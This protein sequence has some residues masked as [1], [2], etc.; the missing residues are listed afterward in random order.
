ML[1][2]ALD[3]AGKVMS[4]SL[5]RDVNGVHS[6][7]GGSGKKQTKQEIWPRLEVLFALPQPA[8]VLNRPVVLGS[9]GK[10]PV[11]ERGEQGLLQ[12]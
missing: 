8:P 7:G 6:D 5:G 11:P 1:R 10:V 2:I 12:R 4:A 3:G 9:D